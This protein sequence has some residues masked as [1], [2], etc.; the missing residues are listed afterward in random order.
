MYAS[1]YKISLW[2]QCKS[3]NDVKMRDEPWRVNNEIYWACNTVENVLTSLFYAL[4]THRYCRNKSVLSKGWKCITRL[5][6]LNKHMQ[7]ANMCWCLWSGLSL[8]LLKF[9]LFLPLYAFL[10]FSGSGYFGAFW[11]W[12]AVDGRT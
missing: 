10:S 12:L 7:I 8:I 1:E 3:D 11:V 6:K 4:N 9:P 5:F 2:N